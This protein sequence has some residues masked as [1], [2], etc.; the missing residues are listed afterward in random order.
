MLTRELA[1]AEFDF[2]HGR[3]VPDRLTRGR[4][5]P[6]VDYAERMLTIYRHGQG[7]TRSDLHREVEAVFEA[8]DDCPLRRIRA[9]CKLLDDVSR[10]D[11][12]RSG[13]AA[14][15][16]R[17]V[18]RA[19]ASFHPLV[20]QPD[21]LFE[22]DE[23]RVK[24]TIAAN[25]GRP[26]AD[27]DR[28]LFADILD[29]QRLLAFDGFANGPALLARY[30]VAQVQAALFDAESLTVWAKQDFKT[31][32]RY[33]K[34]ARLMHTIHATPDGGYRIRLDGPA[35]VL[36][37]TR[38][39][40][41]AMAKFL[42]ALIA[43]R[44]WRLHAKLRIG[45]GG[46]RLHLEL[47]DTDGL[48]SHLPP[49]EEFDSDIER[50][51]AEKWGDEPR[52]GWT[53]RRE[54]EVLWKNQTV[55]IPDFVFEH[56]DG[57]QV[58]LEIIGFWTPEYLAAKQATLR[59]FPDKRLLLAVAAAVSDEFQQVPQDVLAFKQSLP[60]ASVLEQLQRTPAS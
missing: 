9:F 40:G 56:A 14:E 35:S 4:H 37:E 53:L 49:P 18:F 39:Y 25:L 34:L 42:P 44:D 60:V 8:E 41:T 15:L 21:R 31:I 23:A 50:R 5:A 57:R 51:F 58:L 46:L 22:R 13:K 30:N 19:A 33:A 32:L 6:Y 43:C 38:R 16:R 1:L 47:R 2:Q 54:G 20:T 55:F 29:F 45:H 28:D 11:R 48:H 24:E 59:E 10:Y 52:E 27:I 7:R 17:T 36:R 3:V 12:D 26:W